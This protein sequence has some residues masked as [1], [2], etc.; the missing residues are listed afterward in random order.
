[1]VEFPTD[2]LEP[3]KH[4]R[5]INVWDSYYNLSEKSVEFYVNKKELT[6]RNVLNYPNPLFD[7][8]ECQFETPLL[9]DD[10]SNV[11]DM[12][13]RS[14]RMRHRIIENRNASGQLIR[15]IYWDGRD[16]WQQKLANGVYI[17]KI[18]IVEQSGNKTTHLDS[19]FQ[20]LL[21]LN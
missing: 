21:L 5:T 20:K 13:H 1:S 16:Q 6:I 8:P 10:L 17:Y 12:N 14:G 2:N 19:D 9:R 4:R 15:G 18:K 11:I 3:G 7:R